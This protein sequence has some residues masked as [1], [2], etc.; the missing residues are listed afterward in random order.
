MIIFSGIF[1]SLFCQLDSDCKQ[2]ANKILKY[3]RNVFLITFNC[4]LKF[5]TIN[6]KSIKIFVRK[7]KFIMNK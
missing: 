6:F 7:T 1:N 4:F 2:T 5:D 3:S